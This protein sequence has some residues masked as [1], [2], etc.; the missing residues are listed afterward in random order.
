MSIIYI[1]PTSTPVPEP[2][3][4]PDLGVQCWEGD[5]GAIYGSSGD[6]YNAGD[7]PCQQ[8]DCPE[9]PQP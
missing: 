2:T 7:S 4:T 5:S 8:I 3:S 1:T 6:C 9:G